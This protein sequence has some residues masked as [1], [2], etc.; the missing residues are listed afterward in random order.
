MYPVMREHLG[1][2]YVPYNRGN[3]HYDESDV[4]HPLAIAFYLVLL[5]VSVIS[6]LAIVYINDG[7]QG[8][9]LETEPHESRNK[10]DDKPHTK[11][12]GREVLILKTKVGEAIK[13]A[14]KKR[15]KTTRSLRHKLRMRKMKSKDSKVEWPKPLAVSGP[16]PAR[17]KSEVPDQYDQSG[18]NGLESDTDAKLERISQP[19]AVTGSATFNA[20]PVTE[21]QTNRKRKSTALAKFPDLI[22]QSNNGT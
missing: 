21:T 8:I 10:S 16:L 22:V 14:I 13:I 20:K 18:E 2:S 12:I 3:Y 1:K 11:I 9:P 6:F 7:K 4:Q 5:L 17:N 15:A 19:T